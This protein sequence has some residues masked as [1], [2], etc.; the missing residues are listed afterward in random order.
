MCLIVN[1]G[2]VQQPGL[3][4]LAL[5]YHD[6]CNMEYITGTRHASDSLTGASSTV[7]SSRTAG[8]NSGVDML[9]RLHYDTGHPV[10][11]DH[12]I[13]TRRRGPTTRLCRWHFGNI[14]LVQGWLC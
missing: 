11:Q 8:L 7:L 2:Q 13:L 10:V 12:L 9:K 3:H 5:M 1:Y 4:H 6:R 14:Y